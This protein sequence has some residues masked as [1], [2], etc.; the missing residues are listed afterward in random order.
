M[1]VYF[2]KQR[3]ASWVYSLARNMA[4]NEE[5]RAEVNELKAEVNGL[6]AQMSEMMRLLLSLRNGNDFQTAQWPP[7]GLPRGYI[8]P[9]PEASQGAGPMAIVENV[10]RASVKSEGVSGEPLV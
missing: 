2:A 6:K 7:Y 9:N 3:K 5:L 4:T 1:I 8:H 10:Q